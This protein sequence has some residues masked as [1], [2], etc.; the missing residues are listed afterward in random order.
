MQGLFGADERGKAQSKH[1][2]KCANKRLNGAILF[3][4]IKLQLPLII[5]AEIWL[6]GS[7]RGTTFIPKIGN[8]GVTD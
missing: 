4:Y 6:Q 1:R 5:T 2:E 7:G 3:S 8:E